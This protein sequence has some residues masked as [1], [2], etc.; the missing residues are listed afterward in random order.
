MTPHYSGR[1][2]MRVLRRRHHHQLLHRPRHHHYR[3]RHSTSRLLRSPEYLARPP[4]LSHSHPWCGY[5]RSRTPTIPMHS[6][7]GSDCQT[8]PVSLGG[9]I[10]ETPLDRSLRG[11]LHSPGR[12]ACS[13]RS[14]MVRRGC[15]SAIQ[16]RW[17]QQP[18]LQAVAMLAAQRYSEEMRSIR[19][20][21]HWSWSK[22][23]SAS[24][25]P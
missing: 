23:G 7:S 8:D 17:L 12:A 3:H 16:P 15:G 25:Q 10:C 6:T 4:L 5:H 20:I 22:L 11:L 19:Q 2:R 9:S 1:R 24:E 18:R 13:R 21:G 14:A